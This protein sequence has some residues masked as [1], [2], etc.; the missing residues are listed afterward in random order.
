ML[1]YSEEKL[2]LS[3]VVEQLSPGILVRSIGAH[4]G[5]ETLLAELV[6]SVVVYNSQTSNL[7]IIRL[8]RRS[9]KRPDGVGEDCNRAPRGGLEQPP[10][11]AARILP[12]DMLASISGWTRN[13]PC[14]REEDAALQHPTGASGNSEAIDAETADALASLETDSER[15]GIPLSPYL[16]SGILS[17]L[18]DPYGR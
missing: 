5:D 12:V 3:G 8:G 17:R 18:S 6:W 14:R 11:D 9:D 1:S 16:I 2:D 10:G 13:R 15:I 4:D 7:P